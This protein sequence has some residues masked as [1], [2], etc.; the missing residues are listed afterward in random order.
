MVKR[1]GLV[2]VILLVVILVLV[3]VMIFSFFVRPS[4]TGYVVDKQIE[5]QNILLANIVMQVQQNGFVQI[6]VGNQTLYLVPFNPQGTPTP[7]G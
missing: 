6:P 7:Q 3:G 4:Y 5:A 1:T 2:I